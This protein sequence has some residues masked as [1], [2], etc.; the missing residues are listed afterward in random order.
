MCAYMRY[1]IIYY[2]YLHTGSLLQQ[3]SDLF[4]NFVLL[5]NDPH[6]IPTNVKLFPEHLKDQGYA[7]HMIGK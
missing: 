4:Q 6:C 1:V 7:T 2:I 5:S 3:S